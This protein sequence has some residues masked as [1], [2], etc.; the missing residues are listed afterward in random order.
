M[1]TR[2]PLFLAAALLTACNAEPP[3]PPEA[4]PSA[5]DTVEV[6]LAS[7][8][9]AAFDT[10]AWATPGE[11]TVRGSVVY[12]YSCQKC[13]GS[14][15]YGDGG[16][17]TRGDTLRPPSFHDPDWR[18]LNDLEGLRRHIFVG[19]A[20]GMPHWGLEGLKYRDIDAVARYIGN[21]LTGR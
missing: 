3:P 12:S 10:I 14:Q 21:R 19:T 2:G 8:D 17:V 9:A 20:E 15:G 1:R 18:F 7:Y 11:A 4:L 6:A 13:H 16:F 5:D